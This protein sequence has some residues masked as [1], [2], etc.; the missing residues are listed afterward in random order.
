MEKLNYEPLF[1][2]EKGKGRILYRLFATSLFCGIIL[3]WIYRLCNI[4]NSGENGR[5]V[6]IG[7]LGAELWFSFY[8]FITQSVR[9]NRIYRHTFRD[10][11]L[12]RY[13]IYDDFI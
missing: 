8:W 7:M 10:R 3:I 2:T 6:W 12:L 4:P 5:Y 9:W 1:E 11:L 13:V